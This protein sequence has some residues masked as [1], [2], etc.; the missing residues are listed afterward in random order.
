[1]GEVRWR[2]LSNTCP[3]GNSGV[4]D[5]EWTSTIVSDG[6]VVALPFESMTSQDLE[7]LGPGR[8]IGNP[9]ASVRV[10]MGPSSALALDETAQGADFEV[11]SDVP[12]DVPCTEGCEGASPPPPAPMP[13]LQRGTPYEMRGPGW[14]SME[15]QSD[16]PDVGFVFHTDR[17]EAPMQV[18]GFSYTSDTEEFTGSFTLGLYGSSFYEPTFESRAVVADAPVFEEGLYTRTHGSEFTSDPSMGAGGEPFTTKLVMSMTAAR[19]S[20]WTLLVEDDPGIHILDYEVGSDVRLYVNKDFSAAANASSDAGVAGAA[21]VGGE[22]RFEVD[23]TLLGAFSPVST[24]G[25]RAY[26][27]SVSTPEGDQDC[28]LKVGGGAEES[29]SFSDFTGGLRYGPGSYT[30]KATG[31][32]AGPFGWANVMLFVMDARLPR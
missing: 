11:G 27:L 8:V 19:L 9:S 5:S 23:D 30:F 17:A 6:L 22:K 4:T 2:G 24:L 25:A 21:L 26:D 12:A 1:M 28:E 15:V 10:L 29:C 16:G 31:A 14:I 20:R 32:G 3:Q 7:I 18:S 13:G